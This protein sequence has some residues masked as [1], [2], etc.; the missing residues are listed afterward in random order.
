MLLD[1]GTRF[2]TTGGDGP[3]S[4]FPVSPTY[5][6]PSQPSLAYTKVPQC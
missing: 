3:K 6:A 4:G 5:R 1:A 2:A